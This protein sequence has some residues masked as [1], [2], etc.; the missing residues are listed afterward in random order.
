[1]LFR[2]QELE[3]QRLDIIKILIRTLV[4]QAEDRDCN[5]SESLLKKAEKITLETAIPLDPNNHELLNI[6][7]NIKMQ[8]AKISPQEESKYLEDVRHVF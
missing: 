8:Q 7:A 2:A 4:T 5:E 3:P 1:M 6:L